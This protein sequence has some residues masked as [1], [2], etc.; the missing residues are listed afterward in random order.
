[1]VNLERCQNAKHSLQESSQNIVIGRNK[2]H[3]QAVGVRD[4][5]LA[6][7]AADLPTKP[8]GGDTWYMVALI[9]DDAHAI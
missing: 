8:F 6:V 7:F 4:S 5:N 1:M 2:S 9:H 3:H